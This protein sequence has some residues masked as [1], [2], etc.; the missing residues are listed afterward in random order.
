MR[1]VECKRNKSIE[2]L[3]AKRSTKA[4]HGFLESSEIAFQ[5][6]LTL[7]RRNAVLKVRALAA[8]MSPTDGS[9]AEAI[10]LRVGESRLSINCPIP[11]FPTFDESYS[12][13]ACLL[14]LVLLV[15]KEF[16]YRQSLLI[17]AQDKESVVVGAAPFVVE[18][19]PATW[20]IV[21]IR[22]C[23]FPHE[24]SLTES[25]PKRIFL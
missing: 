18:V 3:L 9:I 25:L 13:C 11:A 15:A 16:V 20:T 7:L 17:P 24:H 22:V 8:I 19:I 5:K 14:G 10:I 6:N 4:I 1:Y 12:G 21:Y 2:L 23:E